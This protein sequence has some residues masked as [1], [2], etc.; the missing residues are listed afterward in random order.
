M[1]LQGCET[2]GG[3]CNASVTQLIYK[4]NAAQWHSLLCQAELRS[5]SIQMEQSP[6][7]VWRRPSVTRC[8]LHCNALNIIKHEKCGCSEKILFCKENPKTAGKFKELVATD[9]KM[10]NSF[11]DLFRRLSIS[12]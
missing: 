2:S 5:K 1:I 7:S 3:M 6:Q 11:K 10:F 12:Y 9:S 4:S 8:V